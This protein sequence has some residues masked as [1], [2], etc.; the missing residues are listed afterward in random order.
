[1]ILCNCI[2]GSL[3]IIVVKGF[4]YVIGYIFNIDLF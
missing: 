2:E 1:M 3:F 4:F